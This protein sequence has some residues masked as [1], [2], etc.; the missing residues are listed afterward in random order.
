[1]NNI[2]AVV[3]IF[4]RPHILESQ[5]V[6]ILAQSIPPSS[7]I[8]LNNGNKD[9]DLSKYKNDTFYKVFDINY[10]TGVWTRFLIC[11]LAE[12]EY[13]CVFDDDTIPGSN[14]FKNCITCMNEK[15]ALYGTIGVIF[16]DTGKYDI[17]RRYGW[18][19]VNNGNNLCKMPVDI[20][21][22]SWFFKKI[23]ISHLMSVS[24]KINEYFS[25]GEDISFS[26]VLQKYANIPTYVPPHPP[27]DTSM[28]GSI[29]QLAW[30]YG[31]DGNSG[32]N[33]KCTFNIALSHTLQK[34]FSILSKRITATSSSDLILFLTKIS[35]NIHFALIRP[36]DGE[37][38]ILNN[39]TLTTLD[40][41]TFNANSL[42][43]TDLNDALLSASNNSCNF[44][45]PCR[46]CNVNMGK[47][48]IDKYNLNPIYTT[49]ANIF[50]NKNW[51]TWID[52]LI[53]N[54]IQFIFVG[55][56][57]LPPIFSVLEYYEIPLYLVN[58]WDDKRSYYMHDFLNQFLNYDNKIILFSCG[59][60]AKIFVSIL[61]SK[62]KRNTYIDVGSCFDGHIK[63][64][65]NRTYTI[66]GH[67]HSLLECKFD[68]IL[69]SI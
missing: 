64:T 20:I 60:I 62:N 19:S 53:S 3:N 49:F 38:S 8:I 47:W 33:I 11:L 1:M 59:P 39:I 15:E 52:Y 25:V 4:K 65:S 63:G 51:Q 34:G 43:K 44:G 22:H 14:W 2:T 45:I 28:F 21:G 31:C 54:K 48:Y 9:I 36:S 56:S 61:W 46:C 10:N 68:N 7:I 29:P 26:F 50:V 6:F 69:I 12:T 66:K 58:D 35:D 18:D 24:H 32:S 23:W 16:R 41:W 55:P 67:Y 37:Y 27:N 17:Y 42:L 30:K 5:I 13:I 57:P 40:N